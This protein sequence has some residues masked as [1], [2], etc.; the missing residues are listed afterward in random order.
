[1]D[2][3][4]IEKRQ[5]RDNRG[6]FVKGMTTWNKATKGLTK[7]NKTSFK[8]GHL[9]HNSREDGEL[10]IHH[11]KKSNKS[12]YYIR[13]AKNKWV[14]YNHY[15]WEQHNGKIPPK[16]I[17]AFKDSNTLNCAIDNLECLS[18]AQNLQRNV[19]LKK[20]RESIK[21]RWASEKI[22]IKYGLKQLTKMRVK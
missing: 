21:K 16:H 2:T 10:S 22:R 14:L 3:L 7:P 17:I 12:Y 8:N 20:R 11:K 19:N 9:P 1:M 4:Y 15:I 6:R 5:T 13:V 18:M